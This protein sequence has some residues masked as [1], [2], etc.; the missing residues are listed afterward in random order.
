M[1]T[2][3]KTKISLL[4]ISVLVILGQ[5]S[6]A[7]AA[8]L[9]VAATDIAND[10]DKLYWFLIWLS[11]FFFV[12]IIVA[13]AWFAF[14]YRK[15]VHKKPKY[16]DG[17]TGLEIVWTVIPTI[18]VLICFWWGWVV[19][20]DMI[21][22]PADSMEI[23][24]I[25]KQWLWQFV[26]KNGTT[27]IG[28]VYVPVNKPVKLIMSSEDVLH[29]FFI[30][31]FRV[32]HDVVPG[33]YTDV[34]F[35]AKVPGIHQVFCTEYCGTSHSGMLGR[36]IVLTDEQWKDWVAG[37]KI[38]V[39]ALPADPTFPG[40]RANR[41][42]EGLPAADGK[43]ADPGKMSLAEKGKGLVQAKGCTA[44]H[45]AD[46]TKLVGP[47]Y[48]G[49]YGEDVKLADGSTVKIDDQYLRVS[50]EN[51]TAQV[52]EGYAPS[53]PPYKGL[54]TEEELISIIEYIKSLK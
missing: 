35:E 9:P 45:S 4:I 13:M 33:I 23:R 51:P 11:L 2:Y 7:T 36:V 25:G 39:N 29:S 10:W 43:V 16:I 18:L 30:P 15:G 20:K 47:S 49:I 5:A 21:H 14:K 17:H 22:A 52:V 24:V 48:K 41:L 8:T 1:N 54:V 3:I 40:Y 42:G 53:M 50:I 34:W 6:I 31:N 28:D 46:G 37:K 44:C 26:Y 27:T 38:E 12:G 19:Y 32:K